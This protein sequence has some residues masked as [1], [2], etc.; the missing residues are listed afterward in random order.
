MPEISEVQD[1]KEEMKSPEQIQLERYH[2]CENFIALHRAQFVSMNLPECLW[3]LVYQKVYGPGFSG[4]LFD[5]PESLALDYIED[6][7]FQ[8][9]VK[10]PGGLQQ[11]STLFLLDHTWTTSYELALATLRERPD[12]TDNLYAWFDLDARLA[13]EAEIAAAERK[14]E[15]ARLAREEADRKLEAKMASEAKEQALKERKAKAAEAKAEKIRQF[16]D[17]DNV[18][19]IVDATGVAPD[20]AQA[21]LILKRGDLIAAML[22]CRQDEAAGLSAEASATEAG[23]R[24]AAESAVAGSGAPNGTREAPTFEGLAPGFLEGPAATANSNKLGKVGDAKD[25]KAATAGSGCP[26]DLPW[27]SLSASQL[28]ALDASERKVRLVFEALFKYGFARSYN[29]TDTVD[30]K[31]NRARNLKNLTQD[32]VT[33]VLYVLDQFGCSL[34]FDTSPNAA[35][36]HLVVLTMD[37]MS[38]QLLWLLEDLDVDEPVTVAPPKYKLPPPKDLTPFRL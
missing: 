15:E 32:D 9:S 33:T 7:G 11:R 29:V 2:S 16:A 21:A 28:A 5:A 27:Y 30:A 1:S 37:G 18:Q 35:M 38:F 34:E 17:P 10:A 25:A 19:A 13:L 14:E 24:A 8:V 23:L 22:V 12:L 6:E 3:P 26:S 31:T 20:F 36:H 4:T